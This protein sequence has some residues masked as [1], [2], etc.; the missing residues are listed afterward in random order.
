VHGSPRDLRDAAVAFA[1]ARL[2][3]GD[4]DGARTL[5]ALVEPYAVDDFAITLLLARVDA[6]AGDSAAA[7][8]SYDAAKGLAGERWTA[9]LA[10]EASGRPSIAA[11]R[12]TAASVR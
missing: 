8:R 2:A 9:A 1:T 4:V 10:A 12:I 7:R 3:R 6:A 11:P 5:A